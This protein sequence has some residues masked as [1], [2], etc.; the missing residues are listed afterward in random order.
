MTVHTLSPRREFWL[1]LTIAGI[2]FSHIVD[3]MIMMPLGPQLTR[4]FSISDAQ[5]GLLVSSYTFAAGASGLLA[6][7]YIDRFDRKRLLLALY[8]GFALATLACGLAPTY[9]TLMGARIAAGAFGGVL[10][11]LAHTIV[12]DVIPF[13]RRG[14]AAAVVMSSFSLATVA[15]VP[16]G[17][18]LATWAGWH[19]PFIAIGLLCLALAAAAALTLPALSHHLGA[20]GTASIWRG[21]GEV[22]ADANHRRAFVFS[23]LLMATGFT[24]IPYI[25]LFTTSNAGLQD[26]QIPLLYLFGGIGSLLTARWVGRMTD[27]HG[28]VRVFG[29]LAAAVLLPLMGIALAPEVWA[30]MVGAP[31]VAPVSLAALT[32]VVL[33]ST[34]Q[35]VV[36]SGRMIPGMAILTSAADPAR[37]GTF[38]AFNGAVQSAAMGVAALVGGLIISRDDSGLLRHYWVASL[39]GCGASLASWWVARR[40]TLHTQQSGPKLDATQE[41]A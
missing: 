25:T 20:G 11:A 10:T 1:L 6:A 13:E 41:K 8:S 5:F 28:K 35:F 39:L 14:R 22:L 31:L 37:R 32:L 23:A 3:F 38:M 24:T 36:M 7:G 2:Q 21:M 40:L 4:I 33:L 16:A 26:A 9:G 19:A 34:A 29:W 27:R 30:L 12:A 17:L 18:W 15:G